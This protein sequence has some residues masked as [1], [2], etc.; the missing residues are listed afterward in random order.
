MIK[1][2]NKI[3][4]VQYKTDQ[5]KLTTDRADEYLLTQMV[6]KQH[7]FTDWW[8]MQHQSDLRNWQMDLFLKEL[9]RLGSGDDYVLWLA[10]KVGHGHSQPHD[11]AIMYHLGMKLWVLSTERYHWIVAN[12]FTDTIF[13]KDDAI[14]ADITDIKDRQQIYP[15]LDMLNKNYY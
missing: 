2:K 15:I 1:F 9:T 7:V 3:M 14:Q 4:L 8:S 5:W 6:Q 10:H 11:I 13:H 12:G